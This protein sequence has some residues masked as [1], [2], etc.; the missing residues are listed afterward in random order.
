M[1]Y[2]LGKW[3]SLEFL[4]DK[5]YNCFKN[6]SNQL[7]YLKRIYFENLNI[8]GKKITFDKINNLEVLNKTNN[9]LSSEDTSGNKSKR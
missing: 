2:N 9:G 3:K 1:Y 5:D 6:N 4:F 7:I 8:Y